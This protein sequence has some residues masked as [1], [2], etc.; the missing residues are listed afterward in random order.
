MT[1]VG[2]A[3][4]VQLKPKERHHLPHWVISRTI[5][6]EAASERTQRLR[7]HSQCFQ[8]QMSIEVPEVEVVRERW[9]QDGFLHIQHLLPR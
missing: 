7:H 2:E 5:I 3:E 9:T 4:G 8:S 6:P 1:E